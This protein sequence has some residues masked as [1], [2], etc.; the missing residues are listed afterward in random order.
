MLRCIGGPLD[1]QYLEVP[2]LLSSNVLVATG[3]SEPTWLTEQEIE[4]RSAETGT[5]I[6]HYHRA[7]LGWGFEGLNFEREVLL[8][9]GLEM[10]DALV[11]LMRRFVDLL[12]EQRL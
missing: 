2:A 6:R 12:D 1:G 5:P 10:T 9:D 8:W 11:I 4:H 7:N 3:L